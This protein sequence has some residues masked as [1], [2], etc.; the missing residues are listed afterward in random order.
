[1]LIF[2]VDVII[3]MKVKH[4]CSI[5]YRSLDIVGLYIYMVLTQSGGGGGGVKGVATPDC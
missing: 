3:I 1:M 2:L 5:I 4:G